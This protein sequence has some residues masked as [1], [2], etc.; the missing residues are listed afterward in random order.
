MAAA[1]TCASGQRCPKRMMEVTDS[2]PH[3][4]CPN[5]TTEASQDQGHICWLESRQT[6]LGQVRA[7][8]PASVGPLHGLRGREA[9]KLREKVLPAEIGCHHHLPLLPG[10]TTPEGLEPATLRFR[11]LMLFGAKLGNLTLLCRPSSCGPPFLHHHRDAFP[12][13]GAHLAPAS[14]ICARSSRS[15]GARTVAAQCLKR[16]NCPL[17]SSLFASQ[18][19]YKFGCIHL[20][21]PFLSTTAKQDT[22]SA[23]WKTSLKMRRGRNS[24]RPWPH[25]P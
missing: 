7:P 8:L 16:G 3:A 15:L 11:C 9:A 18:I 4:T 6:F 24:T 23:T 10:M 2:C 1:S 5:G 22:L 20:S 17:N 25:S 21:F 19:P 12:G 13:C 14:L